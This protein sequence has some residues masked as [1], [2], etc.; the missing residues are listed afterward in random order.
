MN[1]TIGG[2]R[3][4]KQGDPEVSRPAPPGQTSQIISLRWSY[5]RDRS[6]DALIAILLTH[7]AFVVVPI[8]IISISP[9]DW[10]GRGPG[11]DIS[12]MFRR[13]RRV[14][15]PRGSGRSALW[16]APFGRLLHALGRPAGT[17]SLLSARSLPSA[18]SLRLVVLT[19]DPPP[20]GLLGPS[21][22]DRA[23]LWILPTLPTLKTLKEPWATHAGTTRA[24]HRMPSH[25]SG[26]TGRAACRITGP[27]S[28]VGS[29]S[30]PLC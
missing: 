22:G 16:V 10:V 2:R 24:A 23:V 29:W 5:S 3:K 17:R 26:Q 21:L 15:W 20:P 14:I 25:E 27:F 9:C 30:P 4:K 18:L 13:E 7:L 11:R 12:R 1:R 19:H 28:S 6:V 8:G